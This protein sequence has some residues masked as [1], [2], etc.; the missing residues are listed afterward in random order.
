[1][2]SLSELDA[3][4]FIKRLIARFSSMCSPG[5]STYIA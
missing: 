3:A 5:V 1:M 2:T 4:R